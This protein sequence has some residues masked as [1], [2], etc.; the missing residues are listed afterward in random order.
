MLISR[1]YP[2]LDALKVLQLSIV[3]DLG[4]AIGGDIPA[5]EQT[6]VKTDQERHDII[7]IVRPLDVKDQQMVLALWEEYEGA[8]SPEAR[9]VKALDKLETILQQAQ[10]A[11][12]DSFDYAFNLHYG[13][14]YTQLDDLITEIRTAIDEETQNCLLARNGING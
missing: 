13:T 5:P 8:T 12:P 4:E 10:G 6:T 2:E 3:H 9:L 14:R 11:T 1:H 7:D